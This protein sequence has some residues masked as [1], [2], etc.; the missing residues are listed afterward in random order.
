[1]S[2]LLSKEEYSLYSLSAK[3]DFT[4]RHGTFLGERFLSLNYHISLYQLHD[5]YV[6]ILYD[7]RLERQIQVTLVVKAER[8]KLYEIHH[9]YD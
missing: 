2:F 5:F 3:L 8:M 9:D 1:M 4:R 6:E 7:I